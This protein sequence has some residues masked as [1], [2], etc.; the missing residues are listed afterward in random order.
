VLGDATNIRVFFADNIL[1]DGQSLSRLG[2]EKE[3]VFHI[4]H[5]SNIESPGILQHR[6]VQAEDTSRVEKV[7]EHDEYNGKTSIIEIVLIA[8]SKRKD[9]NR[10]IRYVS[11]ICAYGNNNNIYIY[12][13][14]YVCMY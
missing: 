2:C 12:M 5:L 6:L 8:L 10:M 4:L 14:L 13:K 11:C 1:L 9:P 7:Y 3:S